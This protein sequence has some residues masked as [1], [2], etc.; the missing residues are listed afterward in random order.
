MSSVYITEPP[1]HG[2]VLLHTTAG[3]VD[4][5]LWPREAPLACRNFCQLCMEGYY[6]G[7][8]FHR[9]IR[10]FMIQGGDPTGTGEGGESVWG[11]PFKDEFHQRIRF[12]HRGQVAMANPGKIDD[13]GSQFFIT[14]GECDWL[15][16]KHTIFG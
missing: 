11:K 13:N 14:L 12:N 6:E 4:I 1:T 5:E 2:K 10:N 16:K 3:D 8:V 9:I 15:D 7:T